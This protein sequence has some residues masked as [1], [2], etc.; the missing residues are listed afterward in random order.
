MKFSIF[1]ALHM[2]LPLSNTKATASSP[3][4]WSMAK[5]RRIDKSFRVTARAVQTA[6]S[7]SS[8]EATFRFGMNS[9]ALRWVRVASMTWGV[10]EG[11]YGTSKFFKLRHA[12]VGG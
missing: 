2:P 11:Q 6:S 9:T 4:M 8:A 3:S 10:L 7:Q 12:S 5:K 1:L